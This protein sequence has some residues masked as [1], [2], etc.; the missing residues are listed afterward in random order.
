[1]EMSWADIVELG[2]DNSDDIH[3][4]WLDESSSGTG[5]DA[6]EH[7]VDDP[8]TWAQVVTGDDGVPLPPLGTSGAVERTAPVEEAGDPIGIRAV[9]CILM[10]ATQTNLS[11]FHTAGMG[12]TDT[13]VGATPSAAEAMDST[14]TAANTGMRFR[15]SASIRDVRRCIVGASLGSFVITVGSSLTLLQ[16]HENIWYEVLGVPMPDSILRLYIDCHKMWDH[17][18]TLKALALEAFGNDCSWR[19]SPDFMGMIDI[20]VSDIQMSY[21]LSRIERCVCGTPKILS[22]NVSAQVLEGEYTVV[23]RGTDVLAVCR[24]PGVDRGTVVSNNIA[25]VEKMFGIEAAA[26]MLS[27]LVGSCVVSDFMARTGTVLSVDKRSTEVKAKGLLTCMG[28]ERP[29]DDIKDAIVSSADTDKGGRLQVYESIMT[30]MD[31][32]PG[33]DVLT[34]CALPHDRGAYTMHGKRSRMVHNKV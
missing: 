2:D 10:S 25:E 15:S 19:V 14:Y 18:M 33:F 5:S 3:I 13:A 1:M 20:E 17:G 6:E 24:A 29:K 23:T 30:G 4:P 31:P 8:R 32:F 16:E 12:T 21:W 26:C 11:H 7:A 27:R 34:D 22:C 9:Q 28:F